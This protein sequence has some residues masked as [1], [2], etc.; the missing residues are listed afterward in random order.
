MDDAMLRRRLVLVQDYMAVAD[1]VF[2]FV[3]YSGNGT[4]RQSRDTSSS[5]C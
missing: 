3:H 2:L 5:V 1:S 4:G